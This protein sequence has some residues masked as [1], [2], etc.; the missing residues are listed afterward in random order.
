MLRIVNI[1]DMKMSITAVYF[2]Q[3]IG[4]KLKYKIT[5]VLSPQISNLTS[6]S[7]SQWTEN[8]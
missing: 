4:I 6:N 3:T 7:D 5:I 2:Y 1:L 8:I